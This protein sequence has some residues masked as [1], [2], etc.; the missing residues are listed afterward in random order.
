[1]EPHSPPRNL[2]EDISRI[3]ERFKLPGVDAAAVIEARRKDLEALAEAN[4]IALAGVQELARKHG[5]ILQKSLQELQN[6][7]ADG[8]A[9]GRVPQNAVQVNELVQ[10]GLRTTFG[11]LRDLAEVAFKAQSEALGVVN[12]RAQRILAEV[13]ASLLPQHG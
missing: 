3:V 7:V 9:A 2:L 11:S 4:R 13:K 1:M 5:E 6:L 8:N 12:R 10:K